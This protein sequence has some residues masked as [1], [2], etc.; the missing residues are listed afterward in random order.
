MTL[1]QLSGFAT[2]PAIIQPTPM[3]KFR[4]DELLGP[5]NPVERKNAP[6]ELFLEGHVELLKTGVR[7]AVVGTR[8][9]SREGEA[10]AARLVTWLA[11][12]RATVVSGLAMGI[13]TIAHRTAMDQGTATIA[14]L[15]TPL[16]DVSPRQNAGLQAEIA[17]HHLLVSQ[18]PPGQ[19]VSKTNFP[20]RNRTMALL[21]DAS[22]IVEASEGSGTLHQGYEALRLGRP[23]YLLRSV[24]ENP[25]LQWPRDML[26]YGAMVLSSPEEL[27]EALPLGFAGSSEDLAF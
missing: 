2:S 23:L 6:A 18:F 12:H 3:Q 4:T 17:Q 27:E 22:I 1:R 20:R 9:P 13:D 15:G 8:T 10:R 25:A 24:A 7:V 11:R 21:C 19:A 16:D 14:V 5:L 26:R